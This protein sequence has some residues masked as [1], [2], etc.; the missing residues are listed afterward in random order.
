MTPRQS[1]ILAQANAQGELSLA[2]RSI[3]DANPE[4][5]PTANEDLNKKNG[6]GNTVRM[7]RYGVKSRAYGVN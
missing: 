6:N 1:E 4:G 7:L 2:L 5:G 3:S